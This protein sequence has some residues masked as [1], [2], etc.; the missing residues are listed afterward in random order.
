MTQLHNQFTADQVKVL[1]ASYEQGHLRREEVDKHTPGIGKTRF[2]AL[3]KQFPHHPESF[4]LVSQSIVQ[5]GVTSPQ[6]P[7]I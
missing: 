2:F 5:K 3:L 7:Q 6:G 1:F 4:S